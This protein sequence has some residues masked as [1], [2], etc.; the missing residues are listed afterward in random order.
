MGRKRGRSDAR[1]V[2]LPVFEAL[3]RREVLSRTLPI[4]LVPPGVRM[5]QTG[6]A[7]YEVRLS[8]PGS[9]RV[10][11]MGGGQFGV[12][13]FGTTDA[14]ALSVS[15][16]KVRPHVRIGSL[17]LGRID[18]KSGHLGTIQAP[19]AT[20]QGTFDTVDG[21][22]RAIALGGIG[23]RA[24]V[25]VAGDVGSLDVGTIQ[26][27]PSGVLHVG[28]SLGNWTSGLVELNGGRARVDGDVVWGRFGGL[29]LKD[30]SKLVLGG[31]FGS[32]RVLD[33]A[34]VMGGSLLEIGGSLGGMEV[35]QTLLIAGTGWIHV[36]QDVVGSIDVG[37]DLLLDGG[38][39]R[40]G[41]G[42]Q[43]DLTVV[44]KLDIR[45][46]GRFDVAGG[47][48]SMG[49]GAILLGPSDVFYVGGSIG[50]WTSGLVGLD[51][52][53]VWI[54]GDVIRG[55]FGGLALWGHSE[56]SLG[57]SFGSMGVLDSVVVVD[58]S[59]LEIGGSLGGM[60]VAGVVR[61]ASA[62][63]FDV[64]QDMTGTLAVG[65]DLILDAGTLQVGR[66][67]QG[68]LTIGDDLDVRGGG[69][70]RVARDVLQPL[71]VVGDLRLESGG[72]MVLDRD[73]AA[74]RI[75][76]NLDTTAGGVLRVGANVNEL[77]VGG[78]IV[79]RGSLGT[80][81]PDI[82]VGLN[83]HNLTVLGMLPD[84]GGVASAD[85]DVIKSIVGINIQQGIFDSLITAG[86]L[87]DGGP[88]SGGQ[89]YHVGPDGT[90]AVQ[91]SQMRAG[92]QIDRL[93]LNGDVVS[94]PGGIQPTRIVAGQ[95]R[96]GMF[97]AAGNVDEFYI[98]GS[99][100][101]AVIVASV[102]P[103]G[104]NGGFNPSPTWPAV[105]PGEGYD[106]AI[107][108]VTGGFLSIPKV[109]G[110]FAPGGFNEFGD[111][112]GYFYDTAIDPVIDDVILSG[113]INGSLVQPY[114]TSFDSPET[115]VPLPRRSTVAG[116]VFRTPGAVDFAGLFAADTRGVFT[117]RLPQ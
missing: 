114:P 107:G 12:D 54:G 79:G 67:I 64:R 116:G 106:A 5:V 81:I 43:G 85:I 105:P 28:G 8:G 109:Y 45:G 87:I 13:L 75:D 26:L 24:R 56:L 38:E 111:F 4:P 98:T 15:R 62:G 100:I 16:T 94:T 83:L 74:L 19:V 18:V 72:A 58:G 95:D 46:G 40:V 69:R 33:N 84:R 59:S 77:T 53:Q 96:S 102:A 91:D 10:R 27:G 51:G 115:P 60:D 110:N 23:P 21:S 1:R 41:R 68:D 89:T 61:I 30:Q 97:R 70:F 3:E 7:L 31:S 35:D 113:A 57:G 22:M 63:R 93:T 11:P 76:G 44:E 9:M 17:S 32:L 2:L 71:R 104:G 73:L 88:L 37:D 34:V 112:V 39:F 90:A 86:V 78:V 42:I 50:E 48:A 49:A 65:D 36:R 29:A 99:L 103:S 108:Y 14:S 47:V 55:Q 66:N 25:D 52:G 80:S 92:A 6:S 101:D 117:G 82:R 20:L